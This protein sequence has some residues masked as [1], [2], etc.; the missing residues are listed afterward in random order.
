MYNPE[1]MKT[2]MLV[3]ALAIAGLGQNKPDDSPHKSGFI[4]ANGVKLHYLDWGGRGEVIVFLT[5]FGDTAHVFDWMAPKFTDKYRVIALTRRGYGESD[6]PETGYDVETLTEDVRAFLDV[7]KI[8]RVHLFGH[9]AGGNEMT[10]FASK[11]P[12]RTRSLVYLDA[13][14]DRREVSKIYDLDPLG[15]PPSPPASLQ[16]RIDLLFIATIESYD[17]TYT[18]IKTPVLSFF[19][20]FEKHWALKPKTAEDKR[21]AAEVFIETLVRP[22]Q[23]RNI[24]RFRREVSHA[25]VIELN[26]TDHYFFRDP[27]RR[28]EV[29][30]TIREFLE[31]VR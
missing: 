26:G 3:L 20:W 11:Y 5:G 12:K 28:D 22:Y 9:S 30:R 19:A 29:I 1:H 25:R 2:I 13:A 8:K 4:T 23:K 10:N 18:K 6:K 17:P 16:D 24:E 27:A 21:K 15:S 7:M 14:Y 31:G